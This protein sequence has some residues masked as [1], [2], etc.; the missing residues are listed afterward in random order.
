VTSSAGELVVDVVGYDRAYTLAAGEGQGERINLSGGTGVKIGASYEAGAASVTM[1]WTYS[2]AEQ[3]AIIAVPVKPAAGTSGGSWA[4]TE[5]TKLTGL[6]LDTI[7]RIRFAVSNSAGAST[8]DIAYQL[9]VAKTSNCSSGTYSA[10]PTT[11]GGDWQLVDSTHIDDGEPAINISGITDSA[12]DFYAGELKDGGNTTGT[13][14][15]DGDDF[16]E[17]EFAVKAI[18]SASGDYCFRLV[19]ATYSDTLGTYTNYAEV[20]VSGGAATTTLGDGTDPSN[21]TVAPGSTDQYLDQFTFQ[22]STGTDSVTALTVTT[23]NT[24]AIAS[25]EIWNEAMT[26]QYFSTDSTPNGNLWEFSGGTA[27]PV[28]TSAASFRVVFTAKDHATLAA[29]TYAVTGTVTAYTCTNSQAGTDTD[30][31]TITVDN[32]PPADASWGT[33]TPGDQQIQLNWTNPGSDFNKV[34]I[35]RKAGD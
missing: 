20:S 29:G 8:V 34:V 1:D 10:V 12:T 32:D 21:S 11:A 25:V 26:T 15:L 6:A 13:I 7:K 9:E 31:A 18:G 22:A 3:W 14:A 19:D 27:I 23:A 5:D 33:I 16:T 30:S 4:Q 2:Q 17:I 35:L 28:T 24:P